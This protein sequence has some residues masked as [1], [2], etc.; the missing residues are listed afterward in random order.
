MKILPCICV[1]AGLLQSGTLLAQVGDLPRASVITNV[2]VN[3]DTR[4]EI[5][6]TGKAPAST[7][8]NA[9]AGERRGLAEA[10][11]KLEEL[12]R[13]DAGSAPIRVVTNVTINVSTTIR[14][15]DANLAKEANPAAEPSPKKSG[16]KKSVKTSASAD[17]GFETLPPPPVAPL[18]NEP[19]ADRTHVGVQLELSRLTIGDTVDVQL[20]GK[21]ANEQQAAETADRLNQE[22]LK[23]TGRALMLPLLLK[24]QPETVQA[25]GKLLNGFQATSQGDTLTI[26]VSIP[27][28]VTRAVRQAVT[29]EKPAP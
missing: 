4:I 15:N 9:P 21:F 22:K 23:W 28:E 20:Q 12:A 7:I 11:R 3:V 27:E 5:D 24:S 1:L 6:G 17:G 8:E 10:V 29:D 25:I 13:S 18:P 19:A 16:N 14:L 2:D 26:S